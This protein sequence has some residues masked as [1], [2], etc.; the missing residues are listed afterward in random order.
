VL[1]H[2]PDHKA[3]IT[4]MHQCL[5]KGGKL[6][7]TIPYNEQEYHPNVYEHF[8]PKP[9]FITQM[10][11]LNELTEWLNIGFSI[12]NKKLYRIFEGSKWN[13]GNRILPPREVSPSD[14]HHLCCITL[15]KK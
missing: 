13:D 2:I 11:S 4:A 8:V 10:Y 5:K 3:A 12:S 6:I 14:L 9:S 7:L 1:E 15:E